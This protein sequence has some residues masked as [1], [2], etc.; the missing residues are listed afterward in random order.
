M[1]DT[2]KYVETKKT[3]GIISHLQH[4]ADEEDRS[5]NNYVGRVLLNHVKEVKTIKQENKD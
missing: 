2:F 5:L 3:E 1:K 4:L